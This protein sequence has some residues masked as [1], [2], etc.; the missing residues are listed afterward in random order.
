MTARIPS[1]GAFIT[2]NIVPASPFD[3]D[4]VVVM[5]RIDLAP[6]ATLGGLREGYVTGNASL[7]ASVKGQLRTPADAVAFIN[8]QDIQAD[9]A[10]VPLKLTLPSRLAWD[11]TALTIDALD[12]SVGQ[13]R[14]LAAG[15][16]GEGGLGAA[17]W[18]STFRGELGD[19]LRIGRPLGVPD[20]LDGTGPVTVEWSSHGR[21]RSLGGDH[22]AGKRQRGVGHAAGDTRS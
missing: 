18:Q 14:L 8:L 12:L 3:F 15:R 17:R 13:G 22:P 11:G 2:S 21:D 9:V 20:S 19:I 16:L 4:A 1:L 10:G 6:L 5:N 7:S